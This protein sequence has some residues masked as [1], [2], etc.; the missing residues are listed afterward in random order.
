MKSN[1]KAKMKLKKD[2]T[3]MVISGNNKGETG[4][5]LVVYNKTDRILVEGINIRKRHTKPNQENQ[6]GGILSKELPIHISNVMIVD[7]DKNPTKLGF[8]KEEVN[9]KLVRVRY[10]KSNGKKI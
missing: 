1:K 3:V 6:Q 5:V 4:R 7:S 10:A 8:R 9:G 2:D